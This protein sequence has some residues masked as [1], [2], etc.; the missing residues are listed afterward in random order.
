MPKERY[1]DSG[2]TMVISLGDGAPPFPNQGRNLKVGIWG[3]LILPNFKIL[4][5]RRGKRCLN[6]LLQGILLDLGPFMNYYEKRQGH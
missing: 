3:W 2:V 1:L 5:F 6:V 4:R